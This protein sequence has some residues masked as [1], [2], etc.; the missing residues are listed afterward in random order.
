MIM[1]FKIL[2]SRHMK[3]NMGRTMKKLF[4]KPFHIID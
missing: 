2:D 1:I 3:M 4:Q